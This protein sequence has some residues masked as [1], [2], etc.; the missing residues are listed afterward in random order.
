MDFVACSAIDNL[1]PGAE[2]LFAQS[3][4]RSLFLSRPWFEI[5]IE[6]GLQDTASVL[7]AC[8]IDSNRVLAMLPLVNHGN[9]T[10]YALKHRYGAF[11][12]VLF[13]GDD[14]DAALE[15]LVQGLVGSGINSLLLEPIDGNDETLNQLQDKLEAA[16]YGCQRNFRFY[17]WILEVEENNYDKYQENQPARLRNTI[18]RKKRKLEREHGCNIRLFCGDEATVAM[19]DYHAVYT[20]SWKASEQYLDFLD[21]MVK[22]FSET[23]WTRL[24]ILYAGGSPVA[25]QLWFVKHGRANIFRLAY[26]ASWRQYS[27][28]TILTDYLMRYV[29]ETDRV[30][31]VDFLTGNEA[32]KQEWMSGR[33]ERLAL[34][35]VRKP[36]LDGRF[37]RIRES[38]GSG[39]R[40][41]NLG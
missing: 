6:R 14:K 18:S 27:P 9:G 8:V 31:E 3:E 7:F 23:G 24:A 13:A 30:V 26:D 28:G 32:Y 37:G 16:G 38:I 12:S 36:K 25:A 29:I 39:L 10:W 4:K 1:P 15:C 35:C 11:Y 2:A 40:K 17:N 34:S 5:L 33:R 22:R 41:L 21:G 19:C 20:R